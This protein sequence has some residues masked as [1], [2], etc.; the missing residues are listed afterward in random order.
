MTW[1]VIAGLVLGIIGGELFKNWLFAWVVLGL[2]LLLLFFTKGK[3]LALCVLFFSGGMLLTM[4]H[5]EGLYSPEYGREEVFLIN[6]TRLVQEGEDYTAWQG[7]VLEPESLAGATVLIYSEHYQPGVYCLRSP[8]YPPVQYRNPGQGWHYKR[9]IYAGE[10]GSLNR[11]EVLS[12]QA[13]SLSLLEKA[14]TSY[15]QNILTNIASPDSGALALALTTGDRSMLGGDIKSALYLTGTGHII[16]LSGLHVGLLMALILTFLRLLGLG[17]GVSSLIT[18]ACVALFLVFA[19]P[20]PSLVRAAL[21]A[22]WGI[23]ALLANREKQGITALQWTAFIMLLYNPLWLF[24]YA[25]VFSLTAT[26]V[27]LSA[28]GGLDRFFRFLPAPVQKTASLTILIQL[29][30]LPLTIG[31]FGSTTLW[32]LLANIVIVPLMPLMAGFALLAGLFTGVL[33]SI[34]ALPARFLLGGVAAFLSLLTEFPLPIKM[35]GLGLALTAVAS[36]G[37]ILYLLGL[38]IKKTGYSVVTGMLLV[39]L[40]FSY[41][42]F[43]VTTVWFLDVGQG[44]SILI[45]SKGQ[46]VLVDC[47][48]AWAGEKA[49]LPTLRYFGV[50][51]LKALIVTH[52]HA[53]HLGGAAPVLADIPVEQIL[54][55]F[56]LDS[57][58]GTMVSTQV[59][60]FEELEVLSHNLS[61]SNVNDSSLLV[62]LGGDKL[63]VTGDIEA[64]GEMLYWPWLRPYQVLKVSH[65]GSKTSSSQEFLMKVMPEVAVI[66][67]GLNNSFDFPDQLTLD[68]LARVNSQIYRTDLLGYVRVDFWPWG[69]VRIK[70]FVGR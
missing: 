6:S 11:P 26:F 3:T 30:A 67:C 33:G 9:K 63:L 32:S 34:V 27:C 23:V 43:Q 36:L 65:H 1:W 19:G 2:S 14:R 29:V 62:S 22:A 48:D 68:N 18:L 4:F 13:V 35:G 10:I 5:L 16:A 38:P 20:S 54:V 49:V 56:P 21:M 60:V 46:W 37:L 15:R 55:N 66:S 64:D 51:R 53:D 59:S 61:L 45:R 58:K 44:D 31:L 69:G 40:V 50:D 17:R 25:F 39:V 8:L 70:T 28:K 12:Y 41:Y 7:K 42:A 52:P 57:A 47:G 24:D